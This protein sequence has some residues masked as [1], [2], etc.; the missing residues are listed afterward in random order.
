MVAERHAQWCLQQVAAIHRMLIGPAEIEGVARLGQL[1]PSLRA[2]FDWACAPDSRQLAA[3]LVRPVAAEL[4]LRKQTEIR[5]W[6][7]RILAITPPTDEEETVYW[8]VCATYGYKQ[9][10]DHQAY[11]RLAHRYGKPDHP[12]VRYSRAYLYDDGEA[13]RQCSPE[14]VAWL[15]RHGEDEAAVHVEIAGVASS[16][17]STGHFAELDAFVSALVDRYRT[18]GP[19]TL[20]YVT[21]AMLGYSALFQGKTDTAEQLFDE[22]ASIDVPDRTSTVNQPAQARA[23]LRRGDQSQAIRILHSYVEELLETDYTDLA[24][25]A[26]IEFINLM[27]ATEHLP[28]AER[29]RAFLVSTGDFG[30][31]AAGGLVTDPGNQIAASAERSPNQSHTPESDLDARQ[32]LEYMRDTFDGLAEC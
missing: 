30:N 26:A 12:L 2:A 7:E 6:A 24:R 29:I 8:L 21:L 5:D 11:E 27:T 16:L 13:L 18:Q 19:P 28:E 22:S 10:G 3:A 9:N 14:A 17:M 1:W 32:A 4:N 23:A 15:Q 25:N 20:L 31:R